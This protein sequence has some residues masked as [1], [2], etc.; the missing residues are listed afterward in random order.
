MAYIGDGRGAA[1]ALN[2]ITL[3]KDQAWPLFM[4]VLDN[5]NLMLQH[6]RIHGDLSAY[7]ILYW[8]GAITLIDFPQV[9]NSR[10]DTG[11]HAVGSR[12]NPDA[13]AIFERDVQ[14]V[15]DYFSA[16]GVRCHAQR[17]AD[18]LWRRYVEDDQLQRLADASLWEEG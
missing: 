6:G 12:P 8:Q 10:V 14:R 18:E 17:L 13:W 3:D 1:P 7:N 16:Q 9:A 15:C 4:K 11:T 5:V 2:E